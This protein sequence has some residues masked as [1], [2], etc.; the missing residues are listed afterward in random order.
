MHYQH[1]FLLILSVFLAIVIAYHV[2]LLQQIA[3]PVILLHLFRIILVIIALP[4]VLQLIM[5]VDLSIVR[6]AIFPARLVLLQAID[7]A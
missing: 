2:L 3:L 1:N 7:H 6:N 5:M 4:V